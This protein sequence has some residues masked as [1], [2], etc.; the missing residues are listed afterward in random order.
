[1]K[2]TQRQT[3]FGLAGAFRFATWQPL[4]HN[5]FWLWCV[6]WGHL[7]L[8][9][10]KFELVI[11]VDR[12]LFASCIRNLFIS[13]TSHGVI[14]SLMMELTLIVYCHIIYNP[15][16]HRT[17]PQ[18]NHLISLRILSTPYCHRGMFKKHSSIVYLSTPN[19][20]SLTLFCFDPSSITTS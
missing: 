6:L 3:W 10:R 14:S 12:I 19:I 13:S 11:G 7:I 17:S 5:S 2:R 18:A 15:G 9:S 20:Q 8:S 4:A 16:W 1:M